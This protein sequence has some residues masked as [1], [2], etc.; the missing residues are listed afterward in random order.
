M[1]AALLLAIAVASA[2]ALSLA[3]FEARPGDAVLLRV[4]G[5]GAEPSGALAGRPLVFWR[6]GEEWRS[7]A[8]LPIESPPGAVS[9]A[10]E[11]GGARAE[12][13]L[14]LLEPGFASRTLTVAPRFIEPPRRVR[15]RIQRDRR[16]FAAA[17]AR[18]FAPPRFAGGFAWPLESRITAHFG[19]QRIL[20]G[21]KESVHY[22]LDLGGARGAAVLAAADGEVVLARDA[23]LSG[24]SV[25]LWH[26]ADVFTVY[27]HLD[28]IDVPAGAKVGRGQRIG[29]VGSTGR[30]TGPHLHWS[31]RVAGL[32][33]DPE[34]ILGIDF[35]SG[36]AQPRRRAEVPPPPPD[37]RAEAP[38]PPVEGLD[39]PA[40]Q[41]PTAEPTR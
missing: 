26:G 28:R 3:P 2:P 6:E 18:P 39:D 5:A 35:A 8:A 1:P 36:T 24:K 38:A 20:N 12:A 17:W 13:T 29:R 23:Y 22:G 11:A 25:V 37:A 30:S 21:K 10:V 19:D 16:A 31:V 9:V 14:V 27:F 15:R 34:S 32:Y 33:V 40:V 4:N 41:G 7:L